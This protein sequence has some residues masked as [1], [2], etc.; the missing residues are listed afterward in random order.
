[1][2]EIKHLLMSTADKL[3]LHIHHSKKLCNILRNNVLP[4][5]NRKQQHGCDRDLVTQILMT[6][7][8]K[9]ARDYAALHGQAENW[10]GLFN[11]ETRKIAALK[12]TEQYEKRCGLFQ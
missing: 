9:A 11:K 10:S 12:L 3:I 7:L 1:M 6:F 8:V 5:L 2:S 4:N